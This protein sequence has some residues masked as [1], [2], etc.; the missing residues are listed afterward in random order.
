MLQY[1]ETLQRVQTLVK[2]PEGT[3]LNALDK[4]QTEA[5]RDL[6]GLQ[7]HRG[8][9]VDEADR[10]DFLGVHHQGGRLNSVF[11]KVL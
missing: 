2:V 3:G 11:Q 4:V 6:D 5:G 7:S 9:C 10:K 8:G 1:S